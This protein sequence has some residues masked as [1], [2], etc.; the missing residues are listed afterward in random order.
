MDITCTIDNRKLTVKKGTTI[1]EAAKKAGIHIPALCNLDGHSPFTSCMVCVVRDVTSEKLVPSCSARVEQGMTLETTSEAVFKARQD[2]LN[3]LLSEHVGECRAP[4]TRTCPAHPDLPQMI[5]HIKKGSVVSAFSVIQKAIPF[6]SITGHICPAPCEMACRRGGID[7]PVSL[8][9][10]EKYT[11]DT[12]AG[13]QPGTMNIPDETGKKAAVIGAGPAG[14]AAAY[15]IRLKGHFCTLFEKEAELGGQLRKSIPE[16][17]LP[18]EVLDKELSILKTIGVVIKTGITPGGDIS[19]NQLQTNY[20]AVVLAVGKLADST[21][22][23]P[24]KLYKKNKISINRETHQTGFP[25]IFACGACTGP[26]SMAIRAMTHGRRTASMVDLFLKGKP[27]KRQI[28]E[29]NSTVRNYT[30]AELTELLQSASPANRGEPLHG[31]VAGFVKDEPEKEAARCLHCDCYKIK[32]CMLR[33]YAQVYD[34]DQRRYE[35]ETRR[36]EDGT[37]RQIRRI[38]DHPSII[39][40]P[41]KCIKCGRCVRLTENSQYGF[42]FTGRGYDVEITVPF[43]FS[44]QA[45]EEKTIELCARLCPTGAL[46]FKE[47]FKDII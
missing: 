3:M 28:R 19:L 6:P 18:G 11:G 27:L 44:L 21:P 15:Y 25:G 45:I 12:F 23:L 34:A 31:E 16:S 13:R 46:A 47:K 14:L 8:K 2:A 41:A 38:T 39:L 29:F 10:L 22:F 37:R 40:E 32:G 7:A 33:K 17:R 24:D 5:R 35:G 1:L 42:C 26:M 4:C 43:D 36:E 20:D 30:Q 9:L